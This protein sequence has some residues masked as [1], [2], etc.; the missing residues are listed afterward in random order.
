M[1]HTPILFYV[2][3]SACIILTAG[4]FLSANLFPQASGNFEYNTLKTVQQDTRFPASNVINLSN[5]EVLIEVNGLMNVVADNYVAVFNAVQVAETADSA[6]Q[7]LNRRIARFQKKLREIGIP[8]ADVKTD[9]ISF[10]P[11]YE[12]QPENK[13]FSKTY[14]EIPSGFEMQKNVFVRYKNS[15]KLD[16]IVSAAALSEIYDLVKVDYFIPNV[17]KSLDSLRAKC[18]QEIKTKVKSFSTLGIKLDTLRK[19]V[20]DNFQVVYPQTRYFSYQAFSRPSLAVAK[21][22]SASAPSYNEAQKTV[23]RFYSQVSYDQYD[24]VINPVITEPVVQLSYT[25]SI[26]YFLK[27]EEKAKN[28]YYILTPTGDLKQIHP[29]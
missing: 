6:D 21:K 23:S 27:D 25:V 1:V 22:K 16:E 12:L 5:N 26:K 18:L 8:E 11:R 10:V 24:I 7:I 4:I 17:Q 2:K 28:N 14:N 13:V 29:K 15:S 19:T 9:M 3:T 20:S